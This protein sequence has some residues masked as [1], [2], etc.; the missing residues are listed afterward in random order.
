[1][2][3]LPPSGPARDRY[4]ARQVR[5]GPRFAKEA[6]RLVETWWRGPDG[7][8]IRRNRRLAGAMKH[9]LS[10]AEL[11]KVEPVTIKQGVLT[12]AVSDNLLLSELR[13]HRHGALIAAL[14]EHGTRIS[15]IVY[16]LKRNAAGR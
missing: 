13:N 12:L 16:R 14:V 15:R 11:E 7:Q 4:L 1:M 10:D 2:D 6:G 8:R 5:H 9:A 3:D